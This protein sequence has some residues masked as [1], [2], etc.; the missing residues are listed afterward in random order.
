ME[1]MSIVYCALVVLILTL[2]FGIV[3]QTRWWKAWRIHRLYK[4]GPVVMLGRT[5]C[6]SKVNEGEGTVVVTA[7]DETHS[8]KVELRGQDESVTFQCAN[9]ETDKD[10]PPVP[11]WHVIEHLQPDETVLVS[12]GTSNEADDADDYLNDDLDDDCCLDCEECEEDEDACS[13]CRK[14]GD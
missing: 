13:E 3:T 4:H 10:K 1:A 2:L 5:I 7:P 9:I 14:H 12:S 8:F 11:V 6:I